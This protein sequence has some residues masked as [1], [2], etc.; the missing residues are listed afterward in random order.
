MNP[1]RTIRVGASACLLGEVCRYDGKDQRHGE[2]IALASR[3][4]ELIPVCPE[5]ECGLP[6]P[7]PP[8][9]LRADP[10]GSVRL[11]VIDSGEDLTEMMLRWARRRIGELAEEQLS[12]FVF[13]SRSPS[14][15]LHGVPVYDQAGGAT[16]ATTAGLFARLFVECFSSLPAM[17]ELAV[18]P[19]SAPN[20]LFQARK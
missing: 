5:V 19:G 18:L 8:M 14:C 2:L 11:V 9:H 17:S 12:G 10:G 13:K 3:G 6:V 15:G 1:A 4:I 20:K 16:S 7:R